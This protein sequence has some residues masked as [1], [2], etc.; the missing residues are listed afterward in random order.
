MVA[1]GVKSVGVVMELAKEYNVS[2]PIAKEVYDVVINGNSAK[3]AF[4]GLL[5]QESGSEAEPG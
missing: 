1:E 2:M 3:D 4:R 5:R